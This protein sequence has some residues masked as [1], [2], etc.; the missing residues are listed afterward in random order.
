MSAMSNTMVLPTARHAMEKKSVRGF[1]LFELML[2]IV[3]LATFA[4]ILFGRFLRYQE[5]A[6]KAAM[7]QT[8]GAIRSALHLQMAGLIT[9]GRV[10]DIPRLAAVNP[11]KLLAERQKNYVG[12][13]YDAR[14]VP[15]GSWYYDLKNKQIVY[16]V[17][18]GTHFTPN[19][20]GEKLVRYKVTLIYNEP[21]PGDS[22]SVSH[23]L[24]G[25]TLTEVEP[26]IWNIQ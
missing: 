14:E 17:H 21:L 19:A 16:L 18:R 4:G 25:V 7:E 5:L 6:E 13:Y 9:R 26:Y 23:E 3:L 1:T 8:A 15:T 20:A 12:E 2:V 22:P 10:A 24:G 11:F